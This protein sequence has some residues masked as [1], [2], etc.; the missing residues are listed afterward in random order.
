LGPSF[1]MILPS[2]PDWGEIYEQRG[3]RRVKSEAARDYDGTLQRLL[4]SPLWSRER[5]Q[6]LAEFPHSVHVT[7]VDHHL[8]RR[9]DS[10]VKLLLDGV[11]RFLRARGGRTLRF[12]DAQIV[13][14]RLTRRLVLRQDLPHLSDPARGLLSDQVEMAPFVVTHLQPVGASDV[15]RLLPPPHE[16]FHQGAFPLPP[17]ANQTL[18]GKRRRDQQRLTQHWELMLPPTLAPYYL[19]LLLLIP[20]RAD[21]DLDNRLIPT[22][23]ALQRANPRIAHQ[24]VWADVFR[25]PQ[26][27]ACEVHY[28][29]EPLARRPSRGHPAELFVPESW[30]SLHQPYRVLV[31]DSGIEMA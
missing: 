11:Y 26:A 27:S 29:L 16:G 13:H 2:P 1:Q 6:A 14:L 12:D 19:K 17:S 31:E 25:I 28:R 10:G 3:K 22:L 8:R 20:L 9:L 5:L 7:L 23:A 18:S 30:I 21:A 15:V 24:V 4:I